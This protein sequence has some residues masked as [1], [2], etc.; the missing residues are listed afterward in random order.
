MSFVHAQAVDRSLGSSGAEQA[1]P[2]AYASGQPVIS[3]QASPASS[4][5]APPPQ[6]ISASAVHQQQQLSA[7][8]AAPELARLG[9]HGNALQEGQMLGPAIEAA[10]KRDMPLAEMAFPGG[11]GSM[12]LD[13]SSLFAAQ[14]LQHAAACPNLDGTVDL[15][16]QQDSRRFGILCADRPIANVILSAMNANFKRLADLHDQLEATEDRIKDQLGA[17]ALLRQQ[18][19]QMGKELVTN[20]IGSS[21]QQYAS[22]LRPMSFLRLALLQ[23]AV[24]GHANLSS[25]L[26]GAAADEPKTRPTGSTGSAT[27][28]SG[29]QAGAFSLAAK[30]ADVGQLA[31]STVTGSIDWW[32]LALP[33]GLAGVL[34]GFALAALIYFR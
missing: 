21:L 13:L 27:L 3:S 30:H 2:D 15:G 18:R 25:G 4:L 7:A 11:F 5:A 8:L 24:T 12:L 14:M 19:L 23:E 34:L 17:L 28:T 32:E 10:L 6:A 26:A 16:S 31:Q 20:I 22:L 9:L 33:M 29:S 1:A